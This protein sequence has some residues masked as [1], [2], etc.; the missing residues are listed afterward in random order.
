[1]AARAQSAASIS[2]AILRKESRWR[3]PGPPSAAFWTHMLGSTRKGYTPKVSEAGG[4]SVVGAGHRRDMV[5]DRSW[6]SW[7]Q[8]PGTLRSAPGPA[9]LG[10]PSARHDRSNCILQ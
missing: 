9:A 1:G 3:I 6:A 2:V 10:V 5:R 8:S 7:R 4:G